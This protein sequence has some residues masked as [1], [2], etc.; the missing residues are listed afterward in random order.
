MGHPSHTRNYLT[1]K[2]SSQLFGKIVAPLRLFRFWLR[3]ALLAFTVALRMAE[4]AIDI[5]SADLSF[6]LLM[7]L[8]VVLVAI[9]VECV[10]TIMEPVL[11]CLV[12]FLN[13]DGV[14]QQARSV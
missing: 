13:P 2:T 8:I 9:N 14:S 1:Q 6:P 3:F 7:C 11:D 4:L 12:E 10:A 5:L